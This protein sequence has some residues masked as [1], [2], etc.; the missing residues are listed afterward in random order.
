MIG[1]SFS[2]SWSTYIMYYTEKHLLI[3]KNTVFNKIV[4][5]FMD[6]LYLNT[7]QLRI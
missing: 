4:P 2:G 6:T 3:K 7:A 5:D 1:V